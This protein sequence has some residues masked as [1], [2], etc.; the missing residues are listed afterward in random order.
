[1]RLA[2]PPA[3]CAEVQT[4]YHSSA[5]I[6]A[7]NFPQNV[8]RPNAPTRQAIFGVGIGPKALRGQG[9]PTAKQQQMMRHD[10]DTMLILLGAAQD[11]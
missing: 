6:A 11:I 2:Q 5:V 1:M 10:V 3:I 7:R 8:R 9:A 4:S